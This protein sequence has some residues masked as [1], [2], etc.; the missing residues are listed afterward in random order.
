MQTKNNEDVH[1]LSVTL[2]TA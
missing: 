2:F 1:I